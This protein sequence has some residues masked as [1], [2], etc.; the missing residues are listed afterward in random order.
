M[1]LREL[2]LKSM[3]DTKVRKLA[4]ADVILI[5]AGA[6]MGLDSGLPDFNGKKC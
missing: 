3:K 1:N 2:S 6:E 5:T 4:L